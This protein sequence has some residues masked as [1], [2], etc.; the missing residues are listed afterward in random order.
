MA[1]TNAYATVEQ[2]AADL[3]ADTLR[4]IAKMELAINA[5]SRQIDNHTGWTHGFWQDPSVVV[6][7]Y[8]ADDWRVLIVEEG[9]STTTGLIVKTD[10]DNDG[11][12]E[13]TLTLNSNFL[14]F[15]LNAASEWPVQPYTE[16]HLVDLTGFYFPIWYN[17]RPG[18]QVT[19]KFGWPAVPD[20]VTKACL[21]QAAQLFKSTDAV[22]GGVQLGL[23][24]SVLR[25]RSGLNPMAA[26]L[27]AGYQR[28][29]LG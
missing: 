28:P 22:F 17:G 29:R 12:F 8:Y 10:T 4:D 15:P 5:A 21:I 9:I 20:D 25:M 13:T 7:T 14:L 6:Q 24:G 3:G 16:I 1:L 26:A 11:A 27:L 23:D 19:A 2:L 18:I